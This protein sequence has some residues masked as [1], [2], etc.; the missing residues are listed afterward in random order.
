MRLV[1]L[2]LAV[3]L[4]SAPADACPAPHLVDVPLIADG[5]TLFDDGGVVIQTRNGGGGPDEVMGLKLTSDEVALAATR[6]YLAPGLSVLRPPRGDAR[7]ITAVD[8]TG[9]VR[10]TLTQAKAKARPTAPKATRMTSSL[11]RESTTKQPQ[12]APYGVA[13]SAAELTL[14]EAP[15]D[16]VIAVVAFRVTKDGPQ[17]FAWWPRNP[18]ERVY[19]YTTGGKGCVPG[20]SPVR[21]GEKV[22]IGFVDIHGR[23]S[24]LS[25]PLVIA[26]PTRR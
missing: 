20:P 15:P 2:G 22:A 1:A 10:L 14:A 6:D 16:E 23:T 8:G 3:F 26:A 9:G 24:L 17:G 5:A 7:T 11:V 25:K 13:A 12:R 21:Q 19:R 4:A 18:G